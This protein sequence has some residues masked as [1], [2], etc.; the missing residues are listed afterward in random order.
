MFGFSFDV[1]WHKPKSDV[2]DVCNLVAMR[3]NCVANNNNVMSYIKLKF[4]IKYPTSLSD[5]S[6][7]TTV[8]NSA[9]CLY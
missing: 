9:C 5:Q 3:K 7:V 4:H 8:S 2:K 1:T 6:P